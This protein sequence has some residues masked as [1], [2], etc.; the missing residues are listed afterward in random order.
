GEV[1][2]TVTGHDGHKVGFARHLN[3]FAGLMAWRGRSNDFATRQ[4]PAGRYGLESGYAHDLALPAS[5]GDVVKNGQVV[6]LAGHSVPEYLFERHKHGR[7]MD[8]ASYIHRTI[9]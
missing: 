2:A 7:V 9:R 5:P 1:L 8:A 4:G 6:A 3:P